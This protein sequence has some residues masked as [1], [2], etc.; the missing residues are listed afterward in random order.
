MGWTWKPR[1]ANLERGKLGFSVESEA[2]SRLEGLGLSSLGFS[3][4]PSFHSMKVQ[5]PQNLVGWLW[6]IRRDS[7]EQELILNA[8]MLVSS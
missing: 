6:E 4:V 3:F 1:W 5:W 7:R 8:G 2:S